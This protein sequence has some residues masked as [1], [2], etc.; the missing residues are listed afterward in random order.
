MFPAELKRAFADVLKAKQEGHAA[1]ERRSRRKRVPA[2][3]CERGPR[4]GRQS[5]ADEP[6]VY[7][8]PHPAQNAG[9]T[10]GPR[11]AWLVPLKNGKPNTTSET[12]EEG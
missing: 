11:R 8:V 12:P 5:G 2:Q 6:A 9:N 10:L 3:S 1:L 7:A 4:A